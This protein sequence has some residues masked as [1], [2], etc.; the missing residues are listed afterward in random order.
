LRQSLKDSGKVDLIFVE[1][2]GWQIYWDEELTDYFS[3]PD[4]KIHGFD[5]GQAD[6][7]LDQKT[8]NQNARSN[9]NL[10][11]IIANA[12]RNKEITI[13]NIF[14]NYFSANPK[15]TY[16]AIHLRLN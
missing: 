5:P 7:F 11:K 6:R 2:V 15:E 12:A 4:I 3:H 8:K 1:T 10:M 14:L 16:S 9:S 13:S